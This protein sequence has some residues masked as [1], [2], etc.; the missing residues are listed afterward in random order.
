MDSNDREKSTEPSQPKLVKTI[1]KIIPSPIPLEKHPDYNK[2]TLQVYVLDLQSPHRFWFV[3]R[4]ELK[5]LKQLMCKMKEFYENNDDLVIPEQNDLMKGLYVA[6]LYTGQWHRAFILNTWPQGFVRVF[7]IDF[8]TVSD[9][10]FWETRYLTE[11]FLAFPA[12]AHRGVLSHVQPVQESWSEESI[13]FMKQTLDKK[14]WYTK[15][16]KKNE[17]DSSY[18]MALR[19]SAGQLLT[20]MMIKKDFCIFDSQFTNTCSG[21]MMDFIDYENGK[22]LKDPDLDTS[23]DSWLPKATKPQASLEDSWL[24]TA[25]PPTTIKNNSNFNN[26]SS[27]RSSSSET[28]SSEYIQSKVIQL[29]PFERRIKPVKEYR[30]PKPNV[31][32]RSSRTSS[33]SSPGIVKQQPSELTRASLLISGTSSQSSP[34][35]VKEQPV[36]PTKVSSQ[37]SPGALKEQPVEQTRVSLPLE[38]PPVSKPLQIKPKNFDRFVVGEFHKIYIHS[39]NSVEEFYFY[40]K[41]EMLDTHLFLKDMK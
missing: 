20:D 13:E 28:K 30:P 41:D 26:A 39:I 6:A 4:S 31:L 9:V 21:N 24:P 18:L 3:E 23:D 10:P 19:S 37:S 33:Q 11:D 22:H 2:T 32:V 16:F 27:K 1:N 34:G 7:Y 35:M 25:K 15:I 5:K 40:L 8:G 38:R 36:E 29:V 12:T 17:K 14:F